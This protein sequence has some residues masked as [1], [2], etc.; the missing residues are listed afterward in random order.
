MA[1]N[2]E[3]R[4]IDNLDPLWDKLDEPNEREKVLNEAERI[5][6]NSWLDDPARDS[7][8]NGLFGRLAHCLVRDAIRRIYNVEYQVSADDMIGELADVLKGE[9]RLRVDA[10]MEEIKAET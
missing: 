6:R 10:V 7:Y 4:H 9:I 1:E 2:L 5:F 3:T 8:L